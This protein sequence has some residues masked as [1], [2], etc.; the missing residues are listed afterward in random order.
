MN[1]IYIANIDNEDMLGDRS[2]VT[3]EFCCHSAVAASKHAWFAEPGDIVILPE[4]LS[5]DMQSYQAQVK[6]FD[7]NAVTFIAPSRSS[8]E[9]SPVGVTELLSRSVLEGVIQKIDSKTNWTIAPYHHDYASS[10]FAEKLGLAKLHHSAA[11]LDQGGA[12]LFN[13]KGNFRALASGCG[14]SLAQGTAVRTP[15]QLAA[16]I[17]D[18]IGKTGAVIIKQDRH[19]GALGNIVVT[20]TEDTDGQ[21]A[22]DVVTLNSRLTPSK[23]A[24]LVWDRLRATKSDALIVEVYFPVSAVCYAEFH[25][26]D[27]NKPPTFLNMGEQRMEPLFAGFEIPGRIPP[28][29]QARFISGATYLVRLAQDLGYTGFIDVDGIITRDGEVKYC[30]V[31]GRYGGCSHV[32]HLAEA[33]L[34]AG[35]GNSHTIV[36]RNGVQAPAF[37][38]LLQLIGDHDLHLAAEKR[39]GILITAEDSGRSG[40]VDYLIAAESRDRALDIERWFLEQLGH[41]CQLSQFRPQKLRV[42]N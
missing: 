34:G 18:Y 42:C 35:Y 37:S 10:I 36:T 14:I 28:Y 38:E 22:F 16:A 25:I 41:A 32:H 39:E 12:V 7:D 13:T 26:E 2:L 29:M 15:E 21:G 9:V 20:Q 5:P 23:A 30:E 19:S 8:L 27:K 11:F 6:G 3:H 1:T 17:E 4:N 40:N 33:L 31:N 24:L